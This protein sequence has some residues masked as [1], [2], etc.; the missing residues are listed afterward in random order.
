MNFNAVLTVLISGLITQNIVCTH[1]IG[2]G[3]GGFSGYSFRKSLLYAVY[4]LAGSIVCTAVCYPVL[5]FVLIPLNVEFLKTL[6][7]TLITSLA[8]F[9][10]DRII[11]PLFEKND[12]VRTAV[13]LG[14]VLG[15]TCLSVAKGGFVE[16]LVY[17]AA[18][19]LGFILLLAVFFCAR[20]SVRYSAV[21]KFL[22]GEP[23]DCII[24]AIIALCF[25]A[26][27]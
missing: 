25:Y 23:L 3:N 8:V 20:L 22:E 10:T 21:P 2:M 19:G 11:S 26:L 16:A 12:I 13:T 1:L 17:A 6:A 5:Y 27:S 7:Y 24:T 4:I 15:I 14:T 9:G 18:Y